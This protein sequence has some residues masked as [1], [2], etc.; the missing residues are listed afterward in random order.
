MAKTRYDDGV[1]NIMAKTRYDDSAL[2]HILISKC[3]LGVVG[4]GF[5][6]TFP[7]PIQ[8]IIFSFVAI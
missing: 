5:K 1:Y 3:L 6:E 8:Y 7:D 2:K 4:H